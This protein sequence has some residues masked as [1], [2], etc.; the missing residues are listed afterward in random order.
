MST[1]PL[2]ASVRFDHQLLAVESEHRVHCMLE[3]TAPQAPKTKERRPLHLALVIDRSGSMAGDKLETT[4]ACAS[5][6]ARRLAPTDELAVVAYDD[7]VRLA[8]PLG[9]VGST[10]LALG[11]ALH[12]IQPGGS[13]NLSGGW[14]KGVEQLRAVP[15]GNGP[16][17]VL[18]L[19]DGLAN[20]GVTDHD[21][22]VEMAKRAGDDGVG[23]TTI[24]FGAGF[25]E[26]LLT[27]M[28]DAGAGNAYF[29]ESPEEAPG[30]FTQEFEG[31]VALV[32]QNL[33]VEI[34][35]REE[36]RMLG[37]LN[38]YPAV[39]VPGGLQVQLG[40][41]YGEE[42]RRVVFE[43]AVPT[44]PTLGV[45]QVAEVIVRY[46]SLGENVEAH[47]L[48][49]P[50]TVNAVTAEEAAQAGPDAGV[51]EEIVVMRAAKAQ[52][53]ARDR[54]ESGDWDGAKRLLSEAAAELRKAAPGSSRADELLAQA[55]ETEGFSRSM[56]RA[57]YDAVLRK[58]MKLSQWQ[59]QRGRPWK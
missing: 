21:A 38:E 41:A 11:Q 47:E 18:L 6:L 15:G 40:D 57:G 20:Q 24:G 54:A 51:V 1:D 28:A 17:K 43:L 45:V 14:L 46:V 33:S 56:S 9:P 27:A 50:I 7:E 12:L 2:G 48:R 53:E 4:K 31:L 32:A 59:R 22:L 49:L 36:V 16:K 29:A 44:L 5:Y 26:N 3:L 39:P 30:I 42:R 10:Q 58:K 13:T 52:R 8:L 37:V 19:T 34:R 25:D 23:T 55:E 35:P